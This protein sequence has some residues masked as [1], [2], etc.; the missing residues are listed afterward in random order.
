MANGMINRKVQSFLAN[1]HTYPKGGLPFGE[2]A[3]GIAAGRPSAAAATN[4]M[5]IGN[6]GAN[7]A[8]P[9]L[10]NTNQQIT[11]NFNV[12]SANL[13]E[14]SSQ[15]TNKQQDGSPRNSL[16]ACTRKLCRNRRPIRM[17]P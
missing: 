11:A 1:P 15:M 12:K 17:V 2:N 10:L 16:K 3:G 13:H 4:K 14:Q 5:P 7:T 6:V 9:K 8:S